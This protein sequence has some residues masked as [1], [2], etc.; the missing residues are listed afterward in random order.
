[1]TSLI[2]LLE[3]RNIPAKEKESLNDLMTTVKKNCWQNYVDI[4]QSDLRDTYTIPSK[5]GRPKTIVVDFA[6]VHKK[7]SVLFNDK[8]H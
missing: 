4:T 1:M 3:L 6:S 2:S 8:N 5:P 7:D